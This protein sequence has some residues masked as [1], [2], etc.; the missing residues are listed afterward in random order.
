MARRWRR[1]G[2]TTSALMGMVYSRI[3][4]AK[5]RSDQNG[6]TITPRTDGPGPSF[7][8]ASAKTATEKL[9]CSNVEL[10]ALDR[11]MA[12]AYRTAQRGLDADERSKLRSDQ[13][14]WLR[15]VRETMPVNLRAQVLPERLALHSFYNHA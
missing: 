7:D 10:A 9:L 13:L 4:F 11:A 2:W 3:G 5:A 15:N 8:C 14:G 12:A 1:N 6:I